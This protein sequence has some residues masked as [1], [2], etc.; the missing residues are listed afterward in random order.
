MAQQEAFDIRTVIFKDGELWVAQCLEY[1]IGVQ[2]GDLNT[3]QSRLSAALMAEYTESVEANGAPFAGIEPAPE[4]FHNLW[5]SST[6]KLTPKV[7]PSIHGD[8]REVHV[9]MALCA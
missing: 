4:Y 7:K 6:N 5:E 3:L 2:A 8:G 1:D 9:D